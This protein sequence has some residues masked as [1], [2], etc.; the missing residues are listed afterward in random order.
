MPISQQQWRRVERALD[1]ALDLDPVARGRYL[2][3]ICTGDAWLRAEVEAL[4]RSCDDAREFLEGPAREFAAPLLTPG[5]PGKVPRR[6]G[7]YRVVS[8]LGEGGM[9]AVYLAERD[10]RQF[11][12]RVALKLVR[13]ELAGDERF[14]RR[15]IE[16]RQ[17][18]ATL[19][20]PGV[21]RLVDGGLTP[22]GLPWYAMEYVEG[23]PLDRFC[24][25]TAPSFER[26]LRLFLDVCDA[27]QYA[28][29][30]LIVHRDLKPSNIL[31]T[32]AGTVKLLDFG[33]A[34]LLGGQASAR[35]LTETGVRPMTPEYAAPEQVLGQPVNVATDV[36]ALGVLLFE[37]LTGRRP[38]R[39]TGPGRAEL[40]L[41]IVEQEP[42]RPS[43]V[44][45]DVG[46]LRRRLR[47][48]LDTIVLAALRKEPDR[49]YPT[50]ERMA[51]DLRRHLAGLPV[52]ARPDT[53]RYRTGKFLRRRGA[54]VSLAASLAIVLLGSTVNATVQSARLRRQSEWVAREREKAEQSADFLVRLFSSV[55]PVP[56]RGHAVTA[57]EV[58]DRGAAR[59]RQELGDQ[60]ELR[61]RMMDA[62][63]RAYLGLGLYRRAEPLLDSALAIRRRVHW[64][65]HADV[66]SSLLA[67]ADLNRSQARF[68]AADS[69]YRAV[70]AMRRRLAGPDHPESLAGLNGL[71]STVRARGEPARSADLYRQALERGRRLPAS[72]H[73]EVMHSLTGLAGALTDLG[74]LERAEVLLREALTTGRKVLGEDAPAVALTLHDLGRTLYRRG[75]GQ[76]AEAVLQ[77][78]LEVGRRAEGDIHPRTAFYLTGLAAVLRANGRLARAERFYRE[79]MEIQR[80]ALPPGHEQTATVLAGLGEVLLAVSN[81]RA[82]EPYLREALGG[83]EWSLVPNHWQVAEA[84]SLLGACLARQGR[85]AEGEP[86]LL[87]GYHALSNAPGV[88]P[89]ALARVRG[90]VDEHLRRTGRTSHGQRRGAGARS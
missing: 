19:D 7:P 60:P 18:L 77:E 30:H 9:G 28:H 66:A 75:R 15:F 88:D 85:T 73:V 53:W 58:L 59:I 65:D 10:D 86:L 64:G 67:A 47:G 14:V 51:E 26:R 78:A 20:H 79:A 8:R 48:D 34:K 17:I 82:A 4:L 38:Y 46:G 56:S 52:T 6:I 25:E 90:Y 3:R 2:D 62:M 40:E 24:A 22:P 61:A 57:R 44:A 54:L 76:E 33:I 89:T 11:R 70:I 55:D 87:N 49:R 42:E 12:Q 21:A 1:G 27:V 37:M 16:E 35:P 63:G 68:A 72:D 83:R 81:P 45:S 80:E 29:R 43:S 31:V 41:A 50:V 74:E 71:A 5:P 84:R 13:T 32:A 23:T 36:F 39:L 69:L